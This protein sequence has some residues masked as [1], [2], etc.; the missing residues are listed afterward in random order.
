MRLNGGGN[1]EKGLKIVLPMFLNYN[2]L[3]PGTKYYVVTGRQ[4]FSAG[5]SNASHFRDCLDATIIGEPTGG[6]PN[7][8]QEIRW[9]T[10]PNSK[11]KA[12][13]SLLYYSFQHKNTD[14]IRPDKKIKPSL[15]QYRSGADPVLQWILKYK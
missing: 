3:H 8:Y 15:V 2:A 9:F 13:C 4:T 11:L 10:L 14:G 5:M 12:S 1:F 6:I 7:G